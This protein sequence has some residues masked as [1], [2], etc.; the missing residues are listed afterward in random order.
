MEKS[1]MN[2]CWFC[3]REY[4]ASQAGTRTF[5]MFLLQ[6]TEKVGRRKMT[7]YKWRKLTILSCRTCAWLEKLGSLSEA[8]LA[9]G[10]ILAGVFYLLRGFN[11]ALA[12]MFGLCGALVAVKI[13]L[14][15]RSW[16]LTERDKAHPAL[17]RALKEGWQFGKTPRR[18]SLF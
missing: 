17:K 2:T 14:D 10:V 6:K 8:I 18:F 7:P 15:T 9:G 4:P 16:R 11:P 13:V 12:L 3:Q 1:T 5:H